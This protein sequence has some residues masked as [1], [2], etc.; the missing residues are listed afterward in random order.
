M[1]SS[2]HSLIHFLPLFCSFQC[3]RL[4]SIQFLCTQA[5]TPKYWRPKTRLF[6]SDNNWPSML[7]NTSLEP[8]CTDHAENP[9]YNHFAL[10]TQK[11]VPASIVKEACLLIRWL[12]IC[13]LLL[14]LLAPTGMCLPGRCLAM[15]VYVTLLY[16]IYYVLLKSCRYTV[17]YKWG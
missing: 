12:A 17:L 9:L 1:K 13:V 8:L 3:R 6:T 10:T 15:S 14:R 11:K 5:H 7:L 16:T 4:C 2:F